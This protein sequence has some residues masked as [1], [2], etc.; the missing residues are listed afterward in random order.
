MSIAP[1]SRRALV[2]Y[3]VLDIAMATLVAGLLV[4]VA[5]LFSG[6]FFIVPLYQ[7]AFVGLCCLLGAL[8]GG[9][10]VH[11]FALIGDILRKQRAPLGNRYRWVVQGLI[12]AA[13]YSALTIVGITSFSMSSVVFGSLLQDIGAEFM[14][15][16]VFMSV[17]SLAVLCTMIVC[18]IALLGHGDATGEVKEAS[19]APVAARKRRFQALTRQGIGKFQAVAML[20]M[21]AGTVATYG[22]TTLFLPE[23]CFSGF[24][25]FSA[26]AYDLDDLQSVA[27]VN[28]AL[29]NESS[30]NQTVLAAL[31]RALWKMTTTQSLG[32][33][34]MTALLDGSE[35]YA[36]R[37]PGCPLHPGE[38]AIQGGTPL[39]ASVYLAMYEVEPNPVYLDVATA[40]ARALMAVQDEVNG[41]FYYDGRLYPD[42]KGYQP[43]PLNTKRAAIFDDDTMQSALAFLLDMYAV[44]GNA[45]YMNAAVRGLD[46]IFQLEKAGGGWPQRSNYSPDEYQSYVTLNDDCMQ[47]LMN[48]MFKAYDVLGGARYLQAAERAGQFLIRVQG[49]GNGESAMQ[50]GAWAQQYKNDQPA[51][52]RRFEPPAMCSADTA[53][54]IDMLMELYLRTANETFLDPI[55]AAV[56]WLTDENTTIINVWESNQTAWSRLYELKTNR[57]IVGN[58]NDQDSGVVYYYDYVPAR[59]YGYSWVGNYGINGTLGNYNYLMI[60]CSKNIAQYLAWREA[61][62]SVPSLLLNALYANSTMHSRGFWLDGEGKISGSTFS[63]MAR[64]IVDYLKVVA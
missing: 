46:Y 33:F 14:N 3:A 56:A 41:G 15:A 42:G 11:G 13:L 6:Y 38:F 47:D 57:L 48:L 10:Y 2:T 16:V 59:D 17:A 5:V 37:G 53:R 39:V 12:P 55:P 35:F 4:V 18:H 9:L 22:L 43:H 31:E 19:A 27:H 45:M 60:N 36:D 25:G 28:I 29:D 32:G 20:A 21:I 58:R 24:H 49:H 64:L 1:E 26:P 34:P 30:V 40:A 62:P 23:K 44:T 50:S 52:A 7:Q 61:T 63:L 51:W 8:G 54:A